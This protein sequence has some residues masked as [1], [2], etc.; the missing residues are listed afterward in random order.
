[1]IELL[2]MKEVPSYSYTP[3]QLR[4]IKIVLKELHHRTD[5]KDELGLLIPDTVD[6]VSKFSTEYSKNNGINTGMFQVTLIP[7][8]SIEEVSAQ[9]YICSQRVSWEM[10]KANMKVIQ[11]W[12]CQQWGHIC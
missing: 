11:C 10:P 2:R 7:R 3:R 8:K 4:R 9:K 6:T 5:L 1:M 12:R